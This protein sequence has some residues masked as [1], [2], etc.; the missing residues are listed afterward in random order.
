[1]SWYFPNNGICMKFGKLPGSATLDKH[2]A[3]NYEYNYEMAQYVN[4][5]FENKVESFICSII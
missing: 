4:V 5:A 1:M 3:E 2:S